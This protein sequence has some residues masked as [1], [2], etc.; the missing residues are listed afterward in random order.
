MST[1]KTFY[2]ASGQSISI[3]LTSLANNGQRQSASIDN[4]TNVWLDTHVFFKIKTGVATN[5]SYANIFAYGSIDGAVTWTGMASGIDGGLTMSV[6][7][8][9]RL[10]GVINMPATSSIYNGGPFSVAKAFDGILPQ[11]WGIVVE[12]K[13]SGVFDATTAS[14]WYQGVA[15]SIV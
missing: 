4:S 11:F 7:P 3:T 1:V 2:G 15:N 14:C 13:S 9:E 12:N 10:I 5:S 6:P 8:N